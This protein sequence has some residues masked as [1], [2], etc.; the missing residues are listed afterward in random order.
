M[1]KCPNWYIPRILT[2][3]G[4]DYCAFKI[5]NNTFFQM[6]TVA[7]KVSIQYWTA[8]R[9]FFLWADDTAIITLASP[10]GTTLQIKMLQ[11]FHKIKQIAFL[12]QHKEGR[13]WD[14]SWPKKTV[15]S[16]NCLKGVWHLKLQVMPYDLKKKN[17]LLILANH[18]S[19]MGLY[20]WILVL[21][22]NIVTLYKIIN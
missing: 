8:S 12:A 2:S 9:E 19:Y 6:G 11:L 14:E 3:T 21:T 13:Q 7:F 18:S 5:K 20:S 15:I 10:I 16:N 4:T 1:D 22:I 17:F